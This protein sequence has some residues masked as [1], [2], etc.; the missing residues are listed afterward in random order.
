MQDANGVDKAGAR[1]IVGLGVLKLEHASSSVPSPGVVL[2]AFWFHL[3]DC[4]VFFESIFPVIYLAICG[5]SC[6]FLS[7]SGSSGCKEKATE[8]EQ[9]SL[10]K[11]RAKWWF[12]EWGKADER[13]RRP[14][15]SSM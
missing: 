7:A 11:V 10:R 5:V 14:D 3:F 15:A 13:Q 12:E 4:F 2:L 8:V 1:C 9:R 6:L